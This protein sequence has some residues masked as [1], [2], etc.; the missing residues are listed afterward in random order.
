MRGVKLGVDVNSVDTVCDYD[1]LKHLEE[2]TPY[3]CN[4]AAVECWDT[5]GDGMGSCG[6]AYQR[7]GGCGGKAP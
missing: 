2:S 3:T 1:G 4:L 6:L 5:V 7:S